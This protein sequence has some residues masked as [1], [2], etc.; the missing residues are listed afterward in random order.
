MNTGLVQQV[1]IVGGGTA[2]W[3]TAAFLNAK[4]NTAESGR[5]VEVV[6]I[7]SPTVPIIGV[8]EGTLPSMVAVLREIGIDERDFFKQCNASFKFG[9]RFEGWN[10]NEHGIPYSFI[11]PFGAFARDVNGIMPIYHFFA[12]GSHPGRARHDVGDN[13]TAGPELIW[14]H[15][16]PRAPSGESFTH[17]EP[18]RY[19]YHVDAPK[20]AAFVRDLAVA[21]GVTHI[22]DDVDDATLDGNGQISHLNCAGMEFGPWNSCTGFQSRLIGKLL[23]EPFLPYDG[24]LL[25]DRAIPIQVPHTEGEPLQVCTSA[26]AMS[27][28]WIWKVPLTAG[29]EPAMSIRAPS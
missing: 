27:A 4:L 16:A 14:L 17:I 26:T 21:R 22:L 18:A 11:H 1:T 28:G 12:Y 23:G 13:L 6:L 15:R 9:V 24:Q 2:G 20:L 29:L 3:L 19:G 25:C 5:R 7:E 8:G 10:L